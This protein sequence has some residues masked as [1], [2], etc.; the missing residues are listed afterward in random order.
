M[1][2]YSIQRNLSLIAGGLCVGLLLMSGCSGGAGGDKSAAKEDSYKTTDPWDSIEKTTEPISNGN[3]P[4]L[5]P[6]AA[7]PSNKTSRPKK[8]RPKKSSARKKAAP[9]K[10]RPKSSSIFDKITQELNKSEAKPTPRKA[11]Q[12]TSSPRRTFPKVAMKELPPPVG[13]ATEFPNASADI[14]A[15]ESAAPPE[16]AAIPSPL[17]NSTAPPQADPVETKV[18]VFYATD[19]AAKFELAA[20]E[21]RSIFFWTIATAAISLV[22]LS[23]IF[24]AKQKTLLGFALVC[25]LLICVFFA[26]S[27][28]IE[29]QKQLR[30][31]TNGDARYT[32]EIIS[33]G[34]TELLDYG[35]CQVNIPPDHRIGTIDSPSIIKLEFREDTKKHIILERVQRST[36]TEF[37]NNLNECLDKISQPQA[38][39]F[40]HGFNVSFE[41][42]VRRTAQ[43]AFDLKFVGAPICYSWASHGDPSSYTQDRENAISTVVRLRKFL[44]DVVSNTG[45]TTIHLVAHSMGNFALLQALEQISISQ[46]QPRKM[47]GQLVMAAPD[48]SSRDFEDR[49]AEHTTNLARQVTLYASSSDRALMASIKVNGHNRAGLAG[50]NLVVLD[51]VDT[52]DVSGIDTSL[53]G[54]SYYG[55]HPK[56]IRDLRA[57][58]ELAKP[59]SDR[60]WLN[61]FAAPD[62]FFYRFR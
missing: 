29:W 38:F 52:I 62:G 8:S 32:S 1:E 10:S 34:E 41:D 15:V 2:T 20:G 28:N 27:E 48:V 24:F 33:A 58:V 31:S 61:R 12:G 56:M 42:A 7:A 3:T 14:S 55:D 9:K 19:R 60:D 11:S 50:D 49:Y 43:I 45:S 21:W 13:A 46:R 16:P 26:R 6:P 39:V 4:D 40:I 22:F 53:I 5:S 18:N 23:A 17:E 44:E 37:Y 59:A 35:V 51:G 54:H 36:K 47:F 30:L 57:L 25:S